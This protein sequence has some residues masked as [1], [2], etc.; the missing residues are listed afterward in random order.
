[1]TITWLAGFITAPLGKPNMVGSTSSRGVA[2]ITTYFS[3][4]PGTYTGPKALRG[5]LFVNAFTNAS[6][7]SLSSLFGGEG[8]IMVT[9][10][11]A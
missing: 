7:S 4:T 1:M 11:T 5:E 3:L 2:I 6:S 10:G 9:L 8:V